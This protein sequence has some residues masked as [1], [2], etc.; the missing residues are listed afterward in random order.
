MNMTNATP[1]LYESRIDLSAD[2]RAKMVAI[3]NATLATT[4]DL[5]TQTKQ[6]HWNVK[7]L[8]PNSE[9]V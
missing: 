6:T 9:T 8:K 7:G 2:V 5:K 1:P 4:I 3:L